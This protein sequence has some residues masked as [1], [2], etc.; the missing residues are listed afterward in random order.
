MNNKK[1]PPPSK[2]ELK[3]YIKQWHGLGNYVLQ[4][5]ALDKLFFKTYP[6]NTD[7]NDIL[8]K[9]SSLNDFYS[10]NIFS[11]YPVAQR[12]LSL[13]VDKR[14]KNGDLT[15]VTDISKVKINKKIKTFYSFAT[16]Y[17][18]HHYP[19]NFAIYDS[20]VDKVLCYFNEID[21]FADFIKDDLKDYP[22]FVEVLN[23]FNEY[24][25]LGANLKNL[26]RYLWLLGKEYF[27][28]SYKKRN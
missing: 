11:I 15:L 26:D 9:A 24:Y 5:N 25:K 18:S 21:K 2:K 7:I 16:K 6:N 1:L 28:R 22:R 23:K 4:E 12:I 19:N 20:Y 14:L 17:C 3:R 13:N 10:T 27:K 8:I